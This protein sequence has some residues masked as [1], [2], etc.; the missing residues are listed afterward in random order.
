MFSIKMVY[1]FEII[2]IIFVFIMI[3]LTYLERKR[4]LL[5]KFGFI[6]WVVIWVIGILLILFHR[7]ANKILDPLNIIRVMDLY[8]IL[9]FMFLFVLVFYLFVKNRHSERKIE[10]LTRFLALRELKNI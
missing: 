6:F 4:K 5:S 7:S 8:M 1:S 10:K 9:A 2:G 3:Y